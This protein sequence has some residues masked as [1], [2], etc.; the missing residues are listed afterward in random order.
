MPGGRCLFVTDAAPRV[1]DLSLS[2]WGGGGGLVLGGGGLPTAVLGTLETAGR[3]GGGG[4][5]VERS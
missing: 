2:A 5:E 1:E 4:L 3:L